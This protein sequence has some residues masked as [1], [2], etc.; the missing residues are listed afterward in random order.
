MK[1]V[2]N[3]TEFRPHS[4]HW[5]SFRAAAVGESVL[6]KPDPKDSEPSALLG[7]VA[8]AA[9]HASR[10]DQ[11]M[12]RK[13]WLEQGPAS[14][15]RRGTEP[16]V[17][18]DWKLALDFVAEELTR[19][20]S[21]HG[22]EAIYGGSYG[23]SSAGRFHHAQSQV[24][25]FLNFIGGYTSSVNT[26][27]AG[28]SAVILP[29]V[30]ADSE[31]VTKD[32]I[33]WPELA[34]NTKLVVAF[35]GLAIKNAAVGGG[36]VSR[37]V[38]RGQLIEAHRNGCNF[39]LI[40][41][42]RDDLP[43]EVEA[44]WLPIRPGADVALMLG[45]AHSLLLKDQIDRAFLERCT[46]G[47]DRFERY[48]TGEVDGVAKSLAWAADLTEIPAAIIENLARRMART[49]TLVS[50]THSLQRAEHGEQPVWMGIVLAAMLGQIGL[51]GG[52][53]SYALGLGNQGRVPLD[54]SIPSLP[55]GKNSV[56]SF[57][58]VARVADMLLRPGEALD[59]D[60]QR[61]TYP[62][63]RLVYWAG[64]NP[65]H[66]HQDLNRLRRAFRAP[67]TV[68]VHEPF[69][70]ATAR[71]ADIVLPTTITLE[72]DDIGGAANDDRLIAMH[73]IV[74]R[75][76][77]A[78]DDYDIFSQLSRRLGTWETFTESRSAWQWI[79][80]LY[81]GLREQLAARDVLAPP[82]DEF[83][84]F[85]ELKLPRKNDAGYPLH[86]FRRNPDRH[87]LHTPSGRIEIFSTTIASFGYADCP[88]H[89]TWLEPIEWLGAVT[90]GNCSLQLIANQPATR[91]HSQL[92]FGE[93]SR[94]SKV[95]GREPI[96]IHPEDAARRGIR[97]GDVV[98][99]YNARGACLAGA[100]LSDSLRRGVVQLSTGA[101]YDP[102]DVESDAP[103]CVHGN[104]NVLTSDTG[105]S[106]LAQGCVGQLTM[107][108]VDRYSGDPPAL[109]CHQPPAVERE[110]E[111]Q[112]RPERSGARDPHGV[113]QAI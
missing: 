69:W 105:T 99:V 66:H 8:A 28:A 62:D 35:G 84:E 109:M 58:P 29:R 82:F 3:P 44:E 108:E 10:V 32:W 72:R 36:G 31:T 111:E 102:L 70:T 13:G 19:V 65:F 12:I 47:F 76:A 61:L 101:W 94:K 51:P 104:P 90:A 14:R 55:Q 97:S 88:G 110:P 50:V 45:L 16:F 87:P 107:V 103:L 85:G 9:R 48:L 23:W 74:N 86:D 57:I 2:A 106:S 25:R 53:F 67:D 46:V 38:V 93:H 40:S 37:H 41:P 43:V 52:G 77:Q 100:I 75:Y 11:P 63:V 73:R 98:R 80:H 78:W 89:P 79:Q 5:G 27:S 92:D 83:W 71:H 54:V 42:L 96:R 39:V 22:Q 4:S 21:T 68:V 64:G 95:A 49:R 15:L 60:G 18:V 81:E 17:A 112:L 113:A 1:R 33:T 91:L 59:Y 34:A 20:R 6:I 30:L 26:Y 56:S 24:H 7:N